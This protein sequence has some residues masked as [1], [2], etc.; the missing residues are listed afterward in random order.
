MY[1]KR[2]K[3]AM[4]SN[5]VSLSP[6][7]GEEYQDSEDKRP[8]KPTRPSHALTGL[9]YNPNQLGYKKDILTPDKREEGYS[10]IRYGRESV[11][12]I[13]KKLEWQA[14]SQTVDTQLKQVLSDVYSKTLLHVAGSTSD[15]VDLNQLGKRYLQPLGKEIHQRTRKKLFPGSISEY[16]LRPDKRT[17]AV[18]QSLT[19]F[20]LNG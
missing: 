15:D 5:R 8:Y 14:M 9:R 10:L 11:K 3:L 18:C 12:D 16:L 20:I 17:T 6:E 1:T 19:C 2:Q 7:P 13:P 4:E